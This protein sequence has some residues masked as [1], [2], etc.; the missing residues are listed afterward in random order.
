MKLKNLS[1]AALLAVL[2]LAQ[3]AF[4]QKKPVFNGAKTK[5]HGIHKG[6]VTKSGKPD[7]RY[8]VNKTSAKGPLTK[9]GKPDM[10]YKANKT[11]VGK[12][13]MMKKKPTKMV[14]KMKSMMKKKK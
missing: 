3:P 9:S 2:C 5:L 4:A 6:P 7:M 13:P 10:R 14:S 12:A 8:K 1:L 11:A